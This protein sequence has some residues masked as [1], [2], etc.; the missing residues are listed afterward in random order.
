MTDL[1]KNMC[2]KCIYHYDGTIDLCGECEIEYSC[3]LEDSYFNSIETY[4]NR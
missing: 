3:Y 1:Y 2:D 4:L